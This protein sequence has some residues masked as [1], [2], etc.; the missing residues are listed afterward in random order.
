M[1]R[2]LAVFGGLL[3][4]AAWLAFGMGVTASAGA[5]AIEPTLPKSLV[6]T[7]I[8][9]QPWSQE[10]FA[11]AQTSGRLVFLYLAPPWCGPCV[12]MDRTTFNDPRIAKLLSD[13]YLPLRVDPMQRPEIASR[14]LLGAYPS[15]LVLTASGDLV[16]GGGYLPP[17]SLKLLLDNIDQMWRYDASLINDQADRVRK[18]FQANVDSLMRSAPS[19]VVLKKAE[20]ALEEHYDNVYGGFGT[21]PKLA[22]HDVNRFLFDVYAPSGEPLYLSIAERTLRAQQK[23]MDPV[24]GGLYRYA[25]FDDWTRPDHAKLLADNALALR[26]YLDAYTVTGDST[27]QEIAQSLLTYM[28]RFLRSEAGWGFFNSQQADL[29]TADSPVSGEEYFALNESERLARGIPPVDSSL[30]ADAN[31]LAVQAYL[32]AARVLECDDCR[33]FALATLDRICTTA[34]RPNG[35]VYHDLENHGSAAVGLLEDQVALAAA[36]LD[37]YELTGKQNYLAL[38]GQVVD[39]MGR[40][41]LD[42]RTGGLRDMEITE[43]TI[44]RLALALHPF[45]TNCEAV[46]T[47][48]R[49]HHIT[50]DRIYFELASPIVSYLFRAPTI[51]NDLRYYQLADTWL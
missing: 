23:I 25:R 36:L 13:R 8:D 29:V 28:N 2:L 45:G 48:M 14:Y 44:G 5:H 21:Q 42:P 51:V 19:N 11:A 24:W 3:L 27:Y 4:C 15:C 17:D 40:H 46:K 39:F 33:E 50:G 35:A 1:M 7:G 47:L 10:S 9:W 20:A 31:C 43:P 38:T 12:E 34:L 37:A 6:A 16:G 18:E 32:H 30:Y 49:L 26:S 22:L 41:L